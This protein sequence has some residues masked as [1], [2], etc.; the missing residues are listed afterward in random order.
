MTKIVWLA[1]LGIALIVSL[2]LLVEPGEAQA[3]LTWVSGMGDDTNNCGR[4]APCETLAR[5]VS[6][7]PDG[8]IVNCLD[9]SGF[10]VRTITK[11]ITIDCGGIFG[12]IVAATTSWHGSTSGF[13][14]ASASSGR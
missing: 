3:T 9:S 6:K 4:T 7:T 11:S 8:G 10:A 12:G 13:A 2:F 5:A 14:G 1:I